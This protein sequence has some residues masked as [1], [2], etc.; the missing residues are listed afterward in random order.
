[1]WTKLVVSIPKLKVFRRQQRKFDTK[2]AEEGSR[3]D[4]RWQ[5]NES[6]LIDETP[7]NLGSQLANIWPKKSAHSVYAVVENGNE[8]KN[9]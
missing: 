3:C 6:R 4:N 1:V 9:P 7:N 2:D 5:E 8:C